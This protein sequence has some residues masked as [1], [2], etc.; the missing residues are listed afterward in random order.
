M[1]EKIKILFIVTDFYQAGTERF[2]YELDKAIDKS[3]FEI[4]IL[5]LLPLNH[6]KQWKDYYYEKHKALGTPIHFLD[7]VK[8]TPKAQITDRIKFRIL[9]TPLTDEKAQVEKFLQQFQAISFLGEYAYPSFAKYLNENNEQKSII[10]IMN[11]IHQKRDL[12]AAYKKEKAYNFCSGFDD[13]R[14][15]E[16]LSAF[17]NYRHTYLPLSINL[18]EDKNPWLSRSDAS[19]KIGIFTRLSVHKPL[20]PF[21]YAFQLLLD[22]IP[23]L[24]LHIFGSGNPE[25]EGMMRYVRQLGLTESVFFRGHQED[26]LETAQ[27]ENLDLVWFHGYYGEPGGF[28]GFDITSI[29]IPQIFWDFSNSA[30][31]K[32]QTI[33]PMY[34]HLIQFVDKSYAVLT[35]I[36]EAKSLSELQYEDLYAKRDIRKNVRIIEN[37]W[38]QT[39][40]ITHAR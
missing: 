38:I 36:S 15:Q 39:A 7:E 22:R 19:G 25:K 10:H 27:A 2:T 37:L 3:R 9:K 28:A 40:S 26:I 14:I 1:A 17:S 5:S 8:F 32:E 11:S 30:F 23:N 12:Y 31:S 13:A 24:E 6:S 29:G 16:E 21:L 20:D 34:N 33:Y 4:H 35:D 18:K